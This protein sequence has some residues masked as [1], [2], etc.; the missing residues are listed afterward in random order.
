MLTAEGVK[1]SFRLAIVSD[2]KART[3]TL[4]ALGSPFWLH[5]QV[6]AERGEA[7]AS[8]LLGS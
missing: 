5:N 8:H 2:G 4:A 3:A 1:V 7:S 6:K